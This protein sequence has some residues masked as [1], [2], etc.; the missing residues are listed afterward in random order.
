[1]SYAELI[2][3]G[4]PKQHSGNP[5]TV[6][7]VRGDRGPGRGASARTRR[8]TLTPDRQP[9]VLS[10]PVCGVCVYRVS[11]QAANEL[12]LLIALFLKRQLDQKLKHPGHC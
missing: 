10:H 2:P 3:W 12:Q 5:G 11:V 8:D 1:M 9:Q 7:E 6:G 4:Q